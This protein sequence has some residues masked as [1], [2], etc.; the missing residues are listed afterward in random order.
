MSQLVKHP[1]ATC[2]VRVRGD[3]MSGAGI[4]PG[5]VVLVDKAIKPQHGHIV[6]AVVDGD[7]TCKRLHTCGGRFRLKLENPPTQ[8]S[9]RRTSNG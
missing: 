2:F 5:S 4:M 6:I 7:F 3:S 9:C 8:I 1:K